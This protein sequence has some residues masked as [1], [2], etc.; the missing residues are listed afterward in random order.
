MVLDPK[1]EYSPGDFV[2]EVRLVWSQI[3]PSIEK[4][5]VIYKCF[6]FAG[7]LEFLAQCIAD[8]T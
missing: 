5:F 6:E 1:K 8:T 4:V 7:D 3:T 2:A